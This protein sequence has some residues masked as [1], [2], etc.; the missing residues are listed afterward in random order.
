MADTAYPTQYDEDNDAYMIT[1]P[2]QSGFT[3]NTGGFGESVPQWE[4]SFSQVF[5]ERTPGEE[6]LDADIISA[7]EFDHGGDFLATGDHGGRVVLF[8]RL[9]AEGSEQQHEEEDMEQRGGSGAYNQYEYRYLTEFQS[10][11][12]E[13]DYLKSLEIEEKIN[14][15]RWIRKWGANGAHTL[16]TTNDKTIKLWK[17][18]ERKVTEVDDF[19]TQEYSGVQTT[20][21]MKSMDASPSSPSRFG[22]GHHIR[23]P[24]VTSTSYELASKCRKVYAAGHAYHINSISL[25]TDEETFLSADDLR[26]NLW[27]FD[28]PDLSFN[29]VDIKPEVMEDL[30]EVITCAEF[31]PQEPHIFAYGSSKGF[32][33]LADMRA[34]ALCDAHAKLFDGGEKD[35]NEK[36]FFSEIVA[37]VNAIK[38]LGT[39]G[40]HLLSR[41]YLTL[42]VWDLRYEARPLYEHQVHDMIKPK[43]AQLYENDSIFDKFDCCASGDGKMIATGTYSNFFRVT[44]C[45]PSNDALLLESSR[46]PLRRRMHAPT[47]KFSN[48]I[49]GFGRTIPRSS[50]KNSLSRRNSGLRQDPVIS[51]FQNKIQHLSWHPHAPVIATAA[52]NSLYLYTGN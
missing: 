46:D 3:Q 20:N 21:W 38:F 52:Q 35:E 39:S 14:K 51:D 15:I 28:R 18:F 4:W 49:V 10:H 5:G 24:R 16:L 9:D 41:D 43:L 23:V 37:S 22:S 13:F 12:P 48:R 47:S 30:T 44:P 33:R 7:V 29:I 25:C 17:V 26:I 6:V 40:H 19:N 36:N 34:S 8:E 11:D 31:H 27:H 45:E 32:I 50:S 2:S 1:P 42:K